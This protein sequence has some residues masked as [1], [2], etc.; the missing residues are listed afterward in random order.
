VAD[1]A[2]EITGALAPALR[3]L[4][5][6]SRSQL[7][8][9]DPL[10]CL[11]GSWLRSL[12]N[13]GQRQGL[14]ISNGVFSAPNQQAET[15]NFIVRSASEV[16][17]PLARWLRATG[18]DEVVRWLVTRQVQ[19]FAAVIPR[20]LL[21]PSLVSRVR[22]QLAYRGQPSRLLAHDEVVGAKYPLVVTL[23]GE[24]P[25]H[26]FRS[27]SGRAT[28]R[29]DVIAGVES[30]VEDLL[31]HAREDL[32]GCAEDGE[33]I[34]YPPPLFVYP[35]EEKEENETEPQYYY[36]GCDR[37]P[38]HALYTRIQILG[39]HQPEANEINRAKAAGSIVIGQSV[40]KKRVK[41]GGMEKILS[42]F[43]LVSVD[44]ETD[45]YPSDPFCRV[46]EVGAV[47]VVLAPGEKSPRALSIFSKADEHCRLDFSRCHGL[48]PP[49]PGVKT[50]VS[51][52]AG[53]WLRDLGWEGPVVYLSYGTCDDVGLAGFPPGRVVNAMAMFKEWRRANGRG[54]KKGFTLTDCVLEVLEGSWIFEPHRATEDALATLAAFAGM[55]EGWG[56]AESCKEEISP[57][58]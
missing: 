57:P 34:E 49:P 55:W 22:G 54:E 48:S 42:P 46:L 11:E 38:G 13:K 51:A 39:R 5:S 16:L 26:D 14:G 6:R 23:A 50:T 7:I 9:G 40:R 1:D 35:G 45:G 12:L 32:S 27:A 36:L 24:K 18:E 17:R 31:G 10:Q 58:D 52:E 21:T 20:P 56:E 47:G 44:V 29:L 4:I 33:L 25:S 30:W 43:L 15:P 2:Q 19:G 8:L 28:E 41:A 37:V 53:G 3:R